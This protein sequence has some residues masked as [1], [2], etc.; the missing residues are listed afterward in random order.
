MGK[1]Y[2]IVIAEG[3]IIYNP[4]KCIKFYDEDAEDVEDEHDDV[5][6]NPDKLYEVC[7]DLYSSNGPIF[8]YDHDKLEH[9]SDIWRAHGN[10]DIK[11]HTEAE[12]YEDKPFYC[13]NSYP[14]VLPMNYYQYDDEKIQSE[15]I[16]FFYN[17][18]SDR[19]SLD[20]LSL[21]ITDKENFYKWSQFGKFVFVYFT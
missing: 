6:K 19:K 17:V 5:D 13:G 2:N 3:L 4:N 16:T 11:Y 18:I 20:E 7:F 12:Y 1:I 15:N 10:I 8:I 14:F 9:K 21:Q